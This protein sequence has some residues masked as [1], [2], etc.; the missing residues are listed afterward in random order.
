MGHKSAGRRAPARF[1]VWKS[2][3]KQAKKVTLTED[4][5]REQKASFIYGNAPQGLA[6]NQ[7]ISPSS[8]LI[9]FASSRHCSQGS[10]LDTSGYG[11][12]PTH[13]SRRNGLSSGVPFYRILVM[14]S[15]ID[16]LWGIPCSVL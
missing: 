13:K 12:W 16:A 1:R 14:Q 11:D 3:W 5:L 10:R 8:L 4:Q 2:F 15:D 9:G 7:R 6:Y